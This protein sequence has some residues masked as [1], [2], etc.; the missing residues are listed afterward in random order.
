MSAVV[1]VTMSRRHDLDALRA[2]AMLI[3]VAFHAAHSFAPG[4]PWLAKDTQQSPWWYLF[5]F[6]VH[7]CRMPLFFLVSG[8]FTALLFERKG[9]AGMVRHRLL[10]LGLPLLLAM[11]SFLVA[12]PWLTHQLIPAVP[13]RLPRW[14]DPGLFSYLWFLWHLLWLVGGFALAIV[15]ARAIGWRPDVRK[16][17]GLLGICAWIMATAVLLWTMPFAPH[18]SV[19]PDTSASLVPN[20]SVLGFYGVFFGFGACCQ[21]APA[22]LSQLASGW[23]WQLPVSLLGLLPMAIALVTPVWKAKAE[24]LPPGFGDAAAMA[25]EALYAW[26]MTFGLIGLA[27]AIFA[28]PAPWRDY[29]AEASYWI[30]LTHLPLVIW[31]QFWVSRLAWPGVCKFALITLADLLVLLLSYHWFVRDTWLGRLLNGERRKSVPSS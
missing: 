2:F 15:F 5:L 3:G 9:L 18:V 22:R 20:F 12:L 6:A 23:R 24:T 30:Y 28:R 21:R 13:F 17:L 16:A 19:G 8:Y 31:S 7:G 26:L 27:E 10:R 1:P 29:L 4:M 25:V 14:D 11:A